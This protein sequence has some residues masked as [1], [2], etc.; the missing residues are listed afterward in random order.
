MK[1]MATRRKRKTDWIEEI[2]AARSAALVRGALL[3]SAVWGVAWG[4]AVF[5]V[6]VL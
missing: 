3:A 6:V 4:V 2:D 5:A 1:E